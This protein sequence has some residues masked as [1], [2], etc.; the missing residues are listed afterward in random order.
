MR[1]TLVI[2]LAYVF[3][4][5]VVQ[6]AAPELLL[7]A[8]GDLGQDPQLLAT[9]IATERVLWT[10]SATFLFSMTGSAVLECLGMARYSLFV[11][12]ALM[13][14]LC[15]P[16]VYLVASRH[17]GDASQ[18]QLCWIIGSVFEIAIG[19]VY[20]RRIGRAVRMGEN[21]LHDAGPLVAGKLAA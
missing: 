1:A 10:F 3:L 14:C 5:S 17:R 21:R 2:E 6:D 4:V 11:R 16:L 8:F 13:W 7:R 20:F 12:I 15:I 18:L 9:A 19:I